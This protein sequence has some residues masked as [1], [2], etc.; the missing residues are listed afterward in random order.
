MINLRGINRYQYLQAKR[1]STLSN[2][3]SSAVFVVAVVAIFGDSFSPY[4]P[5]VMVVLIAISELLRWRSDVRKGLAEKLLRGLD[6]HQSFNRPIS[7]ADI[8]DVFSSLSA[9]QR[10]NFE[11]DAVDDYFAARSIVEGPQGAIEQL[12]ESA[13]YTK[14]QSH[15]MAWIH[16]AAAVIVVFISLATLTISSNELTELSS[17]QD[18]SKLVASWL[19]LLFSFGILRSAYS[20]FRL[21]SE[22]GKAEARAEDLRGHDVTFDEALRQWYEYQLARSHAP[23]LPNWLWRLKKRSLDDSWR[24]T[25]NSSADHR[26]E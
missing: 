4:G 17:R 12:M 21:Y 18:V 10:E 14:H 9:K 1:L 23:L 25:S 7:A 24:I 13:W 2:L 22:S 5:S 16:I 6:L 20:Y 19:L 26:A 11:T 3:A 15:I 8:R